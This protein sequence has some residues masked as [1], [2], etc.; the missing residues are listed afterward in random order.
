[1]TVQNYPRLFLKKTPQRYDRFGHPWI[2]RS[3]IGRVEKEI[4]AG[5]LVRVY[6]EKERFLGVGTYNPQSEISVRILTEKEE[7]VEAEFFRSRVQKALSHRQS[8]VKD[9]NA[10]RLISSE[11][12]GLPGLVVDRYA[13]VLVVQFLTL[14]MERL[15]PLVLQ[16]LSETLVPAGIFERSD[17]L[18]R[19]HEG[20]AEKTGWLVQN[21]AV[22]TEILERDL[23]F[24]IH[25]GEG[26]KTG[27]YLDQRENRLALRDWGVKGEVLDAFCFSGGFGLHLAAA[28]CRVFGVDSQKEAIAQAEINRELNGLSAEKI[29]F[30]TANVFDELRL[31]EKEK[32]KFDLVVLDP[33]SFVKK[34]DELEG[35]QAGYKEILLRSMKLLREEGFLAVFSCSYRFDENLLMQ[36]SLAAAKDVRKDLRVLQFMKQSLDHPIN[37][38]IPETYYLKGFLFLVSSR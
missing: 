36:A 24:K 5:S 17:T 1:M 7:T 13:E 33:P 28:G 3:Q 25:F 21:C 20:L 15:R 8:I 4:P 35:A 16:T 10:F 22:E 31:C 12:D 34:S 14:G 37:P 38:F 18:S 6:S 11:A 30:K 2:Y 32:R 19:R 26:H 29:A 9:T 27:F 23:R